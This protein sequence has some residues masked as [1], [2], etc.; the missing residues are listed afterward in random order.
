M[1]RIDNKNINFSGASVIDDEAVAYFNANFNGGVE[2]YF[3]TTIA[4]LDA[5]NA[6]VQAVEAD[7]DEFRAIVVG[8]VN[9]LKI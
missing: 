8:A 9:S 2:I 4:N 7:G 1:L 6:N 5:Y 3:N